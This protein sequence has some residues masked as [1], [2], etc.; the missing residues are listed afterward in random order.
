MAFNLGA[1][2]KSN[3]KSSVVNTVSQRISSAVPGVNSQLINSALSGGDIKGALLGA[4]QGAL[5]NQLLGGIQ[6]KLGGLIANSE[7]L[8]GISDN[9]LKIVERGLADLIGVTGEESSLIQSQYRELNERSAY[10]DFVD[11]GF[12]PSFNSDK[13]SAS[14]IPNPLRDHNSFN[15]IIT[16]GI[17]DAAEYNNPEIYRSTGFKNHIIQSAGGGLNKRYQVFD[18]IAGNTYSDFGDAITSH[19]E[20]YID[21]I[22][23]DA[24]VAPNPNTRVTPG[25]TMS[26]TVTEPYS[27]GNFIQA[28]IGSAREAGYSGY[29]HAPFCLRFDFVGWNLDGATDANFV[30]RPMFIPIQL[31]NMD[32]NVSG[33]GSTYQVSAVPMSE[34]GLADNINKI[35]TSIKASGLRCHEILE[36]NDSSV[37]AA[38]NSHISGLEE[39]GALAPYDRYIIAFPKDRDTLQNAL[40]S[41]TIDESAFTT[42]PEEKENQRITAETVITNPALRNSF[43]TQTITITPPNDTYAILKSFAENTDLMNAIGLSTLNEDTNAPGNSSEADV[44]AATNPE[45]NLVDTQSIAAQPADKARDFQFNQSQQIT[46]II[47]STVLQTTYCAENATKKAKNGLYKWFKI[48]TQ[49]FLDE[50]PLTEATM[51]RRPKVYVYSVM[52]YEVDEAIHITGDRKASNTQGL[53]KSAAKEYNYIYSGENED[54]LN[55]DL[56]FNQSFLIAANADLGTSAAP[57][58]DPD[59]GK[60]S[61]TQTAGDSGAT[62]ATPANGVSNDDPSG[63]L[64]IDVNNSTGAA[65]SNDVRRQ[66]AQM[67][68]QTVTTIPVD[69]VQA[70]MEIMGDPFF[71][72]QETGN[73][74]ARRAANSPNLTEDGTMAYQ[75]G[76]VYVNINFRSPFDYQVAGAT[77][78]FPLIVPGFSGL[79][80]VWAVVN[81]FSGGKFTQTLKMIRRRGQDDPSTDGNTN[82][83]VVDNNVAVNPTTTQSDGTVGQSGQPS[84]DCMPVSQTDDIRKINPA[85]GADIVA[86]LAAP[87]T[88]LEAQFKSTLL[89]FEN[90]IP[91]VDF[92]IANVPDLTKVIPK[93]ASSNIGFDIGQVDPG[94][95]AAANNIAAQANDAVNSATNQAIGSVSNAAKSK[96]RGLLG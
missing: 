34:S 75:T 19:A 77:M 74:V 27:M 83:V 52:P 24:L 16:L 36:T 26:F 49:V 78:E 96:I 2:L 80:M 6:S 8:T 13:S 4:A 85:I 33:S 93:I 25:A 61:N 28:V 38:I 71:I 65:H 44:A 46:E 39:A 92:N 20:Y 88:A 15:Y 35:K 73:Y 79:F 14:R 86:Q 56:T 87:F 10:N 17:L 30:Q 5:G 53:K 72:P 21:D 40:K 51:G 66:I 82:S 29:T 89:D 7:E 55:F 50:S 68:H 57:N 59:Q 63:T 12:L 64:E 31:I 94:L 60:T 23:F 11:S 37:T 90:A 84:T 81:R 95:A 41:K 42:S 3:L 43:S 1:S 32:F 9:P 70:E 47:E 58:R 91:G 22:E 67:F 76:P 62:T 54:V 18:E 69:L 48:D 45:T